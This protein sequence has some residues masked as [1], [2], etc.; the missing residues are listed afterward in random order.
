MNSAVPPRPYGRPSWA[1]GDAFAAVT[2]DDEGLVER[3]KWTTFARTVALTGLLVL[4]VAMDLG[5]GPKPAAQAPE[6]LLYQ[7]ETGFFVLT[8]LALLATYLAPP[9]TRVVLAWA[10]LAIDVALAATLVAVTERTQS[11]F[12]F[13]PP[14]AVL[15]GAA[16][17]ERSGAIAAATLGTGA[18]LV[19]VAI[20]LGWLSSEW[21][22]Y[23]VVWLR[24]TTAPPAQP[25]GEVVVGVAVQVAA[26]YATA[27]LSSKLVAELAKARAHALSEQ[28]ELA[29]LRQRF[30]DVF[31]SMPDGLLTV[32]D[33]GIVRSAND[34]AAQIIG[35]ARTA[36]V[37]GRLSDLLPELEDGR[38]AM[39]Q[40]QEIARPT[41]ASA[42]VVRPGQGGGTQILTVRAEVLRGRVV[43][44]R[45]QRETLY[46]IRDVT[47]LRAREV[48][49]RNRERLA[50]V[51]AM[52]MA[53]AHEI[54][55][56]LAS[57][58][59]AVQLLQST[60]QADAT[61]VHLGQIIVRETDQ[62]SHWIGEF[63]E[64]AK[65]SEPRS[66][67]LDFAGLVKAKV[68]AWRN[69]PRLGQPHLQVT[70][71]IP[72]EPILILADQSG[73]ASLIWN[74]L[75]NAQQAS[76]ESSEPR[77][78]VSL[79]SEGASTVL[80]V[81]DS[82][83]GVAEIDVPHLFE[84]F[85]TTRRSGTGLGLATV[86]RVVEAHG[87]AVRVSRSERLGGAAFIVT[88]PH[89]PPRRPAA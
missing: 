61:N 55:N 38:R 29:A 21:H 35:R 16:L 23:T 45:G 83:P 8:F 79:V 78:A 57:I 62:L 80:R 18:M 27:L 43:E 81:E 39:E 3:I 6:V 13:A 30:E 84:P 7:L 34:A 26:L 52:A 56:P 2:W 31:A 63:L 70:T 50:S 75:T 46:L 66:E 24:G 53:V 22:P 37:G 42:E 36:V 9:R 82:G 41:D 54:R 77:V 89:E 85:Y 1:A 12:L 28:I 71:D 48:A 32:S 10:S 11:V 47:E 87:G 86:R 88:L 40:T 68:D 58:S 64:F 49:H 60:S 5:L 25:P 20:D 4:T 69:D 74:L 44:L 67:R 65:P 15:S 14:L 76:E 17:L 51:G 72:A 59:G 19:L 73:M 33:D